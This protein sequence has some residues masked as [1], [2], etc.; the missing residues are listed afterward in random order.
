M[1]QVPLRRSVRGFASATTSAPQFD[2]EDPLLSKSLLTSEELAVGETA[3]RY[4][5]EQLLP[6]VLRMVE[7]C[8]LR[9][10]NAQIGRAHV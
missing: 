4:C 10:K 9:L 3:E 5:Q 6:R 7:F 2:W 8:F 1:L